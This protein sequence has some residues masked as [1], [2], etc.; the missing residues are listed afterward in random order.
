MSGPHFELPG[1]DEWRLA[2]PPAWDNERDP[3]EDEDDSDLDDY[4]LHTGG[5]PVA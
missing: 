2:Y 3:E 4:E 5:G 1:Y